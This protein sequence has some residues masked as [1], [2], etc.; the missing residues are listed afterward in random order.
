M[1][2]QDNATRQ[3]LVDAGRDLFGRHGYSATGLKAIV[4]ES[5]APIGSLY[6]FFP[7]GKEELGA[8]AMAQ[9]GRFFAELVESFFAAGDDVAT[10]TWRFFEGAAAVVE[11]SGYADACPIATVA[12]EV[13]SASE[14][15]REACAEAFTSWLTI[16]ERHYRA[17]GID[18]DTA[19]RLAISAFCAIEGA[20]LLARTLRSPE[21]ILVAGEERRTAVAAAL[22]EPSGQVSF[23]RT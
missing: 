18:A 4:R 6:H 5:R 13:A 8:E 3:R 14:P 10:A 7:G 15:M 1:A 21:P 11:G 12:G 17:A 9:S 20:F 22:R 16:L 23:N 2:T 19:H